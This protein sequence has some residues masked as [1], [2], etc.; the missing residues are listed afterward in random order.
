[1]NQLPAGIKTV[2]RGFVYVQAHHLGEKILDAKKYYTHDA[3]S[4]GRLKHRLQKQKFLKHFDHL[5]RVYRGETIAGIAMREGF[6][7]H[8]LQSMLRQTIA[9][10]KN[11]VNA[12][13]EDET[14][15]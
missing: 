11:F 7:A 4:D 8:G 12:K 2:R 15:A 13:V 1:M 5:Y 10:T 9:K 6:N 3:E 14:V